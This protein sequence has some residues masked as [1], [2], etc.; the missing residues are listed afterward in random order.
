MTDRLRPGRV[1]RRAWIAAPAALGLATVLVAG[2]GS[3]PNAAGNSSGSGPTNGSGA[4]TSHNTIDIVLWESHTG[5][6]NPVAITEQNIVNKFNASQRG[7]H[8]SIL[9]TSGTTKGLA[10]AQAGNPPVLAEVS[11]YDGQFRR[12]GFIIDQN[13]LIYGPG[14]FTKAQVSSFF[15]GVIANGRIPQKIA[16]GQPAPGKQYRLAAGVKVSELFYNTSMFSRAGITSCPATWTALGQD[17]VKL[18]AL[19][20][21]PMGFKDSSAHIEPAFISNGGSLYKPGTH[22]TQTEYDSPAGVT[23]F[24]QFRDWYSHKLFVFSHG[25]PMRAAIANKTLAI[26]DGTSAGWVKAF[27]IAKSAGVHIGACPYPN[28]TSGHSG[29]IIQGLGFV[30]FTHHTKAQ[31]EAAF[32]FEQFWE[33]P[34]IQAYWAQGSG[35]APATRAAV[36][37]IPSSYLSGAGAGLAVSIQELNSP[38]AQPRGQSDNYAEVDSAVDA[39]FFNAVTGK[40]SVRAALAQLDKVDAGYLKGSTKI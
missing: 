8:V 28:G 9:E 18:K 20:V 3:S 30:I 17:L 36:A 2:C 15:P 1:H 26:E 21:T 16:N 34:A 38:Y 37:E 12:G 22:Q 19:G 29:N 40:I 6:T 33:S 4:A 27:E 25:T 24:T 13:P 31:Q 11:H 5:K 35:F 32:D 23:T 39:A 7:V 10:A 14:G